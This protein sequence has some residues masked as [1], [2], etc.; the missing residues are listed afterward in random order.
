MRRTQYQPASD[1][2]A[3]ILDESAIVS[4]AIVRCQREAN[5]HGRINKAQ[6]METLRSGIFNMVLEITRPHQQSNVA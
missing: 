2:L 5:L 1:R 4:R 3:Q 6:E